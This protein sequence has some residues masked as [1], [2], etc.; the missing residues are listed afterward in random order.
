MYDI[1]HHILTVLV[2]KYD[3]FNFS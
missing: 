2:T 1:T 3:G